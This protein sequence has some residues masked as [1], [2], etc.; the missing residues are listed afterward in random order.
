MAVNPEEEDDRKGAVSVLIRA[1]G[2][3]LFIILHPVCCRPYCPVPSPAKHPTREQNDRHQRR[4]ALQHDSS[5]RFVAAVKTSTLTLPAAHLEQTQPGPLMASGRWCRQQH[6]R[7]HSRTSRPS[8]RAKRSGEVVS[9]T[10]LPARPG[11]C[12][13]YP[14]QTQC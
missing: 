1:I 4:H 10:V 12:I 6:P 3:L 7:P 11:S 13:R 5:R 14:F 9:Y 8:L 2:I